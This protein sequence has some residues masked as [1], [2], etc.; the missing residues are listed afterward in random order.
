M[1]SH[2]QEFQ[3]LQTEDRRL[4][5][6]RFLAEEPDYALNSSLLQSALALMGHSVSRD[7]VHTDGAWLEENSLIS[8]EHLGLARIFKLTGRGLDAACGR[9][10]VPGVKRPAPKA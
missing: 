10:C 5:I 6:L 7:R 2:N 8:V 9:A 4:V 1:M 3:R